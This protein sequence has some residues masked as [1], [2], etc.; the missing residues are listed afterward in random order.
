MGF[1]NEHRA[2]EQ[3][4]AEHKAQEYEALTKRVASLEDSNNDL[5]ME[6]KYLRATI[7]ELTNTLQGI[8]PDSI[9]Q[10]Q[11]EGKQIFAPLKQTAIELNKEISDAIRANVDHLRNAWKKDWLEYA[12]NGLVVSVWHLT[13]IGGAMYYIYGVNDVKQQINDIQNRV[14]V[15]QYNQAFGTHYSHWDMSEFYKAWDNQDKYVNEQRDKAA[16]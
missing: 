7:D 5:R 9:E 11:Q 6:I 2:K 12:I 1:A 16:Q 8:T 13:I 14:D 4:A 10:F 3:S 15:I